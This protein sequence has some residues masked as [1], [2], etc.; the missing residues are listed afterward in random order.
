MS[1][2]RAPEIMQSPLFDL[3]NRLA[4]AKALARLSINWSR[5]SFASDQPAKATLPMLGPS[6]ALPDLPD[7]KT[8]SPLFGWSLRISDAR[9][10][11]ER[12]AVSSPSSAPSRMSI[13]RDR[14]RSHSRSP[15]HGRVVANLERLRIRAAGEGGDEE[16]TYNVVRPAV[17]GHP[18]SKA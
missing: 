16:E 13:R 18:D 10:E 8:K 12:H 11:S 4:S 15:L 14:C 7:S 3:F 1:G 17:F 6:F 5:R 2:V 9:L